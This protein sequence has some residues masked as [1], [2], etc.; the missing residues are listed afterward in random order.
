MIKVVYGTGIEIIY[1]NSIFFLI[2]LL[3]WF[4]GQAVIPSVV[5]R[6]SDLTNS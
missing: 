5:D 3:M 4:Q 6:K 2:L 1:L